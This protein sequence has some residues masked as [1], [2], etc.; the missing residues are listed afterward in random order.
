MPEASLLLTLTSIIGYLRNI[1]M[2]INPILLI[3]FKRSG[4]M[5]DRRE[6]A[7]FLMIYIYIVFVLVSIA[8]VNGTSA[9]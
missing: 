9:N 1:L 6:G 2:T 3:I 8:F 5:I 4:Y 7:V